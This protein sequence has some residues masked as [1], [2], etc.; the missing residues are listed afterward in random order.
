MN[1]K[2][3]TALVLLA[4]LTASLSG[5]EA[6]TISTS[7]QNLLSNPEGTGMLDRMLTEAFHR[8]GIRA[9]IVYT[10]T[11]S[12]LSDVNAGILDA[13][14]NRITGMEK[15]YPNLIMVPEPNMTMDFVAFSLQP[16]DSDGWESIRNLDIGLVRGWKILEDNTAGFP[17][18]IRVPTEVELFTMLNKERLHIALYDRLTGYAVLRDLGID[19]VHHLDPPLA[20]RDMFLYVHEKHEGI[21]GSI[22]LALREMK[23]DGSYDAIMKQEN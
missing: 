20:S 8:I 13:E 7:Y 19:R 6:F 17:H 14:I 5:E 4:L 10:P 18:V 9:E 15:S 11:G 21:V 16:F 3:T 2:K 12:S 23:A 1:I 22:A